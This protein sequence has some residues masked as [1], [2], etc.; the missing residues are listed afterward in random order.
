MT[1]TIIKYNPLSRTVQPLG[2]TAWPLTRS[3]TAVIPKGRNVMSRGRTGVP[4]GLIM[5]KPMPLGKTAAG[6]KKVFN[7][8]SCVSCPWCRDVSAGTSVA[9]VVHASKDTSKTVKCRASDVFI[10]RTRAVTFLACSLGYQ[11]YI[12][13][14]WVAS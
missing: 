7:N 6:N 13:F 12:R 4:K 14:E 2:V 11:I 10:R 8:Y 3:L 5:I 1:F 9:G